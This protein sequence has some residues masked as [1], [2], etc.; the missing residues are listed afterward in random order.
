MPYFEQLQNGKVKIVR[1]RFGGEKKGVAEE[2][3]RDRRYIH[4]PAKR[5]ALKNDLHNDIDQSLMFFN[6]PIPNWCDQEAELAEMEVPDCHLLAKLEQESIEQELI[7]KELV[8]QEQIERM[9]DE[10]FGLELKRS[11]GAGVLCCLTLKPRPLRGRM[12]LDCDSCRIT[13]FYRGGSL[14]AVTARQ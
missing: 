1:N 4:Q 13:A 3:R 8:V 6:G 12:V 14:V 9:E 11:I 5:R 10:R 7:E 2:I